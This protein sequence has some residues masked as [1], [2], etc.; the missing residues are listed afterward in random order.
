MAEDLETRLK[1]HARAFEGLMS[2][3]PAKEY[4]GKDE[5][6]TSTQWQKTKKQS[7]EE[8]QAAKRAKLDPA[9]HKSAKDVMDENA[10]KR[11]RELE[12][13]AEENDS[14][15]IDMDI[16]KEKPREG[17]KTPV[18]KTKK[19]KTEKEKDTPTSETKQPAANQAK[20]PEE[21]AQARA[22]KRKQKAEKKKEKLAQK[23]QN[24]K[25]KVD[26]QKQFKDTLGAPEKAQEESEGE[27]EA[28]SDGDDEAHA[29]NDMDAVD[30]GGLVDVPATATPSSAQSNAS[31][32]SA[33]SEA[34]SKSSAPPASEEKEKAKENKPFKYDP[35]KHNEYRARLTAKLEA[36]RAARKADGPDGRPA[37]N[38]AELIEARRKKEAER[39]AARKANREL[40]KDDEERLKAEEQLARI[41]GASGSPSV[42]SLR[43]SPESEP[44]LAFGKV[45]WEDG[46]QL[47]TRLSGLMESRKKKGKS[48]PKTALAA[49]EK[50][51]ARISALDEEK[52]KDI[53]EK[54]LWLAAKKR[55][56]GEKVHDDPALL[57]KSV[58]RQEKQKAK[59]KQEWKDRLTGV[60][61]GKVMKQKKREANLKKRK[62]EK[63]QKGKKKGG[64][65][66]KKPKRPGFEGTF[67]AR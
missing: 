66:G 21:K 28:E 67:K 55:A 26:L 57:R 13:E 62:E 44:N 58:K 61:K 11:K 49:A 27:Q 36:L 20:T 54:D 19:Q 65:P 63:G 10:R 47:D 15:D 52:R 25:S 31:T 37:R 9:S 48:D 22:E 8:R 46:Q 3:I 60:Q 30:V 2:L 16:E 53:E 59:S 24:Q 1:S 38:R 45:A 39:K 41:R 14:S 4:Y 5:S 43:S 33:V 34:S 56:Q 29:E 42:F 6:I 40:A 23:Q 35:T 50:K 7:R 12:Q 64:K 18:S 32:T 17:L 51:K